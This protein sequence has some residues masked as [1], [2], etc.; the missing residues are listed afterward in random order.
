M[1]LIVNATGYGDPPGGAGLRA[2][3]LFGAL[4]GHDVVFVVAEDTP[5]AVVPPG[6]QT[7][8]LPLESSDRLA[9]LFVVRGI[10]EGD[11]LFTDHFP[12]ARIPTV[13]TAH[14]RGKTPLRRALLRRNLRRAARAVCVSAAVRSALDVAAHVVPNGYQPPASLGAPPPPPYLLFADPALPHK[15]VQIAREAARAL[16][17]RLLEV[18][19]GARW[20]DRAEMDAHLAGAAAVLCPSRDEGFGMVPLE[21]MALG[22]P[23]AASDLPAHREVCGDVPFYAPAGDV[24]AFVAAARAAVACDAARRER[25]R[26][27]ARV[28]SWAN[29]AR[30]L[31]HL[32]ASM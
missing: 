9:R 24:E 17:I 26:E 31:A 6:A 19:R 20:L 11:V 7:I 27:R 13:V 18:G 4:E 29:A 15:N 22:T 12:I 1:R 5:D 25:G 14:D 2:R 16:G 8:R 23:V 3:H 30:A 10:D 21:A 28:F 32:L